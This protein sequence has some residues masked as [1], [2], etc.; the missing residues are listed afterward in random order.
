[1]YQYSR[2]RAYWPRYTRS[3]AV[4]RSVVA[5]TIDWYLEHLPNHFQ[6]SIN[7]SLDHN[8]SNLPN[9]VKS[10]CNFVRYS[11][12]EQADKHRSKHYSCQPMQEVDT[13]AVDNET[14]IQYSRFSHYIT[15]YS[16][17]LTNLCGPAVP[18]SGQTN[19]YLLIGSL[20]TVLTLSYHQTIMPTICPIYRSNDAV[21]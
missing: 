21:G 20:Y 18:P 1:M 3:P 17:I 10:T 16:D 2:R 12:N 13:A 5:F 15:S 14:A 8:L 19:L 9:F 7:S 11:A 4:D 6:N